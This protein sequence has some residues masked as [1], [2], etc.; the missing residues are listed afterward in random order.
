MDAARAYNKAARALHGS[1]AKLN[2]LPIDAPAAAAAAAVLPPVL[3]EAETNTEPEAAAKTTEATAAET[4]AVK[5]A[6]AAATAEATEAETAQAAAAEEKAAAA[7]ASAAADEAA[8]EETTAAA[9]AKSEESATATTDLSAPTATGKGGTERPQPAGPDKTDTSNLKPTKA[10]D[11]NDPNPS[12]A[13]ESG[14][15]LHETSSDLPLNPDPAPLSPVGTSSTTGQEQAP[16]AEAGRAPPDTGVAMEAGA[17]AN[18]TDPVDLSGDCFPPELDFRDLEE[19]PE[20]SGASLLWDAE[21]DSAWVGSGSESSGSA[22]AASRVEDSGGGGFGSVSGSG[23]GSG[24]GSS[25]VSNAAGAASQEQLEGEG[26]L[27]A[28]TLLGGSAEGEALAAIDAAADDTTAL[29]ASAASTTSEKSPVLTVPEQTDESLAL[30][31]STSTATPPTVASAVPTTT[32]AAATMA[33]PAAMASVGGKV[34]QDELP[35]R[36]SVGRG[37]S[38]ATAATANTPTANP[39]ITTT[40]TT[41]TTTAAATPAAAAT[42]ATATTHNGAGAGSASSAGSADSADGAAGSASTA[43]SAGSAGSAAA[44]MPIGAASVLEEAVPS[45]AAMASPGDWD[46]E[47]TRPVQ[48]GI[49]VGGEGVGEGGGGDVGESGVFSEEREAW[50]VEAAPGVGGWERDETGDEFYEEKLKGVVDVRCGV[51]WCRVVGLGVVC[52]MVWY[53][54]NLYAGV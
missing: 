24:S 11:H 4:A 13:V 48:G 42:T 31:A 15:V 35:S 49:G 53:G 1:A 43:S 34:K 39:A 20:S 7:K 14:G 18:V 12:P 51:V 36:S 33:T 16:A 25:G 29:P 21:L 40:T 23:S 3:A 30:P 47:L 28:R 46:W 19:I 27:A 22:A 8:A 52:R 10:K 50:L 2:T 32:A 5:A 37:K 38:A 45:S 26:V 54:V 6:K 41:T 44:T 9:A 17:L